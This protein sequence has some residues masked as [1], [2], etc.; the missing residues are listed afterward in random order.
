MST[1]TGQAP[2][3]QRMDRA[4]AV[5]R[6]VG[7]N[8]DFLI[9]SGLAGS[10]KDI[11]A[12]EPGAPNAFLLG[13]AMGAAVPMGIGLA[14]A[15][16]DRHVLVVTGD[17]EILMNASS[18]ATAVAAKLTRFS[19]VVV[20]NELYGETGN[21]LGHTGMGIDLAMVAKGFGFPHSMF[22]ATEEEMDAARAL[23]RREDGPVFVHLKVNEAPPPKPSSRLFDAVAAKLAFREALLA[24]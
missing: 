21:Q 8:R 16:P 9:I 22:A 18:L 10:A 14:L 24:R 3:N 11:H 17:G 2:T 13:G 20:D 19:V 15:Q 1:N 7:S 12:M 6:V 23:I 5:P 4:L